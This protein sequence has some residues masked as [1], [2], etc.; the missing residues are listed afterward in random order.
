[1]SA[2]TALTAQYTTCM[3]HSMEV[4]PKVLESQ[5]RDVFDDIF[6]E[7]VKFGM[8]AFIA[9][10]HNIVEMLDHYDAKHIV[11][12]PGMVATSGAKLISNEAISTLKE[13]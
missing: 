11:V 2:I 13:E 8:L 9:L 12:H 5:I 4:T 7:A 3:T 1:M 10:I 6:P